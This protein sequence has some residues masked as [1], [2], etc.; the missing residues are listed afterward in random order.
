MALVVV[1]LLLAGMPD[2]AAG[3][4]EGGNLT[5]DQAIGTALQKH[6]AVKQFRENLAASR[7]AIGVAKANYFPQTKFVANYYYGNAFS[8]QGRTALTA[9]TGG[10]I[11][12][13]G[14]AAAGNFYFYQFQANQLLYD[15]GKTPGTVAESRANFKG[16]EQDYFGTRQQVV[17]DLRTAYFGYLAARRALKVQEET[18]RQNQELTKQAQGFFQV[19]LKAKIDVTKAEAN[20]YQAEANLIQAK[21]NVELARV[22][23]MNALGIKTWPYKDVEDVLEVSPQPRPLQELLTQAAER[24]PDLQ[25]VR[26]QQEFNLAA[27][28]VARSG[29][30]PTLN[31]IAAYGWQGTK[32]AFENLPTNWYVGAAVNFPLFNGLATKYS[33]SQNKAQLRA[34]EENYE[35]LRQNVTKEVNQAYLNVKSGWELI[36]ATKKALEAARENLRL[37]WGRYQAGIGTIIEFT[38][39]QV[40][41]SQA[42]LNFVQALY[43]YRVYEAQLDKAIGKSY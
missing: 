28:K 6:P 39:A 1:T 17:L 4:G 26:Y 14:G 11:S 33:V 24:R 20:L 12:S 42:D 13:F 15:F 30:F 36:R 18:V 32:S 41:F 19:G 9:V 37:A 10:A 23:L 16:S 3:E 43:N 38:D 31:S 21:N 7:E 34:A 35:V 40:Q 27:I 25:K 29:Y 2:R 22:N 5:L 8:S